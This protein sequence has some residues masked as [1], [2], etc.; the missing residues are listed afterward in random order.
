MTGQCNHRD[1]LCYL[2]RGVVHLG[3]VPSGVGSDEKDIG[4][5]SVDYVAAAVV[6]LSFASLGM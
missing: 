5:V 6:Y 3:I 4:L 1:W 2:L